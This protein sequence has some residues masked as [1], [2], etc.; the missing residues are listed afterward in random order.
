M[1]DV[2]VYRES[3]EKTATDLALTC[4]TIERGE[5]V[6]VDKFECSAYDYVEIQI[7]LSL[8]VYFI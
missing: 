2:T 7:S 8:I 1:V 5:N 6:A 4:L 3:A